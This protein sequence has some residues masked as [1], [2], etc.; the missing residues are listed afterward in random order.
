MCPRV[1]F[2]FLLQ[3][4]KAFCLLLKRWHYPHH[5][6]RESE[7]KSKVLS[8][9]YIPVTAILCIQSVVIIK[10]TSL[11]PLVMVTFGVNI[12]LQMMK[13][14]PLLLKICHHPGNQRRVKKILKV[15][16]NCCRSI[17][18]AYNGIDADSG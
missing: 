11:L 13:V 7:K 9:L 12:L 16:H 18:S 1:P 10:Y 8:N 2:I 5:Q 14:F 4:A 6:A 3:M 17:I 15:L